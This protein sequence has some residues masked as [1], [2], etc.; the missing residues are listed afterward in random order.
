[1]RLSGGVLYALA[2]ACLFALAACGRRSSDGGKA[3]PVV[4]DYWEKWQ[5]FEADAM[6]AIVDRFNAQKIRNKD[7]RVIFVRFLSVTEID[8][9][10]LVATAGGNPPDLAG[11]FEQNVIMFSEKGALQPLD[12]R[13]KAAGLSRAD[14]LPHV[15]KLCEHKG[16]I[17]GLPSVPACLALHYNKRL[18][19]EAGFDPERPPR[20]IWELDEYAQKLT[21]LDANGK[22]V[23]LGF[24]PNEPGWW[25]PLWC[26]WFGA[27][28][29]DGETLTCDSPGVLRSL[30]WVRGYTKKYG[31]DKMNAFGA[32]GVPFASGQNFFMAGRIAMELQGIYFHQ[33]I[34][35]Y[36][37]GFELGV[38]PFPVE[39]PAMGDVTLVQCDVLSIPRGSKHPDEAWEFILFVQRPEMMEDLCVRQRRFSPLANTSAEFYARHPHPYIRLFRR[40]AEGENNRQWPRTPIQAEYSDE[41][42]QAFERVWL[43]KQE[44]A[45]AMR[46]VKRR[47]QPKLDR[48]NERWEKV[49]DK[50]MEEWGRSL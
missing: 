6:R 46:D 1:M 31:I 43:W 38:A 14:Y 35:K 15:L 28:V 41:L 48:M 25:N 32:R 18:F 33:F 39:D 27:T 47:I 11:L 50:R 42:G 23:Q 2:L 34:E 21:K 5:G 12:G 26:A 17:W 7:G 8:Q 29:W 40:L 49:K 10:M 24:S 9:K 16:Y 30:E 3:Q 44:P 13:M 36:A 4:I 22:I 45:D 19:R 20:T 37:P